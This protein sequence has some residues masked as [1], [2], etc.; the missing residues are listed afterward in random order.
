MLIKYLKETRQL[1]TQGL[2]KHELVTVVLVNMVRLLLS[3]HNEH[4]VYAQ[5]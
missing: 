5:L 1:V 2:T 3:S 4:F